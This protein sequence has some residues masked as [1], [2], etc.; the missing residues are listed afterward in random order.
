M[1]RFISDLQ[2]YYRYILYSAKSMLKQEVADSFLNWGWL[3]LN[4]IM[5]MLIYAFVQISIFGNTTPYVATFV[6]I[7]QVVWNFF[8]A[9]VG[10]SVRLIKRYEPIISKTYVPKF[11]F[12]MSTMLVNGFK[13]LVSIGLVII[14]L[15]AY[16]L[17]F[18]PQML[19]SIPYLLLLWLISFGLSC[20]LLHWGV[21]FDD[22]A[23]IVQIG[24]RMLFF[25][26][27]VFFDLEGKLGGAVG[28]IAERLNPTAFIILDL[29]HAIIFNEPIHLLWFFI[30]LVIGI[31]L[32]IIGIALIYKYERQYVKSV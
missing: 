7:G 31:L 14:T 20:I 23:N 10:S 2:H 19:W 6:F 5:F 15:F 17:P 21:F 12:V 4:P 8:N 24:L 11:A 25:L 16:R 22:L 9:N 27:G 29:R 26:S 3:V 28:F 30:W 32:S 13:M 1:K 18:T